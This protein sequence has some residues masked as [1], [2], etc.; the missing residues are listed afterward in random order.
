MVA[1]EIKESVKK[2]LVELKARGLVAQFGV[3][4]GSYA[5]GCAGKW[6]DVDLLIVSPR[7]DQAYGYDEVE[8]LW[9]AATKTDSR[10][11]PVPCGTKEWEGESG[12]P[13]IEIAK[14][15]GEKIAA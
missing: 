3:V 8:I 7:F 10:I 9:R 15:E 1:E 13:I 12:S 4:F 11:E 2:Y 5:K 6:S 14:K